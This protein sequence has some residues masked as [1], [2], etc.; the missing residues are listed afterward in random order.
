MTIVL[1]VLQKCKQYN[2]QGEFNGR[3]GEFNGRF[4]AKQALAF[5]LQLRYYSDEYGNHFPPLNV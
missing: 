3:Q 2:G 5:P 4:M 1:S